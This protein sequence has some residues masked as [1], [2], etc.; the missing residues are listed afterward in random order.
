[1]TPQSCIID[2][3]CSQVTSSGTFS[4]DTYNRMQI[5]QIYT[6]SPLMFTTIVHWIGRPTALQML[7]V[8]TLLHTADILHSLTA[9]I[10]MVHAVDCISIFYTSPLCFWSTFISSSGCVAAQCC[11]INKQCSCCIQLTFQWQVYYPSAS[12]TPGWPVHFLVSSVRQ[13]H[14]T[15]KT[16]PF[17]D[18]KTGCC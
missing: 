8:S 6:P 5:R 7:V 9:N 1:M 17:L 15:C 11:H 3:H 14:L 4:R 2:L 10:S 13:N 16:C 18:I 12:G